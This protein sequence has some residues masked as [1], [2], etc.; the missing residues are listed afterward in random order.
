LGG[1]LAAGACPQLQHLDVKGSH[2]GERGWYCIAGKCPWGGSVPAAAA[3]V[4]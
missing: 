4:Y 3:L 2:A 1:A